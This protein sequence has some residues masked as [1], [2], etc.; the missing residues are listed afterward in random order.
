MPLI[1]PLSAD[2]AGDARESLEALRQRLGQVPN[3]Y[4][5]FAH[6]PRVLDAAV[7]MARAIRIDLDPK[8]RELAY[9]KVTHMTDCHVCWHY[10]EP[11]GKQAGLTDEQIRDLGRFEE[12]AAYTELEK[13]ILRFTEQWTLAGRVKD[14]VLARLKTALS[15]EHLV[16]LAATVSQAN[17]TTRFNNVFGVE[18]P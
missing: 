17:L 11:A 7:A 13:D 8:L 2:D 18:L 14:D 6:A 4:R 3:M 10:H 5:T 12:S 1:P 9:L 15:P 16:L